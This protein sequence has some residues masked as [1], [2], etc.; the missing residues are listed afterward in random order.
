MAEL[1]NKKRSERWLDELVQVEFENEDDFEIML[2][3]EDGQSTCATNHATAP[4]TIESVRCVVQESLERKL[5][6]D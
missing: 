3:E 6:E 2:S 5:S 1:E 4:N